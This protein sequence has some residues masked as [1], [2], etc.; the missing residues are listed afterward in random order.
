MGLHQQTSSVSMKPPAAVTIA[1]FDK[2]HGPVIFIGPIIV[3]DAVHAGVHK[4][5]AAGTQQ[6]HHAPIRGANV[7]IPMVCISIG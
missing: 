3:F 7:T 4:D 6:R 2:I 5:Y 1:H